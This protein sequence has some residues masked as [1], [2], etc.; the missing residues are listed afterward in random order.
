M[1]HS[2][3]QIF[4]DADRFQD[5]FRAGNYEMLGPS[6]DPFHA[7][8]TRID[9]TRLGMQRSERSGPSAVRSMSDPRR[10]PLMFLADAEQDIPRR[11]GMELS[12]QEIAIHRP[13]STNHLHTQGPSRLA[14]M[15]LAIDDLA[16]AGLAL[17]GR[18]LEPPPLTYLARPAPAQLGR[19]RALHGLAC[20][21]AK[22]DPEALRRPQTAKA[23]EQDL[24]Q[25]MVSCLADHPNDAKRDGGSHGRVMARFEDFLA[26]RQLEPVYLAEICAAIGASERTLRTCC[27]ERLGMGPIRY[28]WLR[29][30]NLAH[31]ALVNADPALRTVTEIVTE[32]GFWELGR[33]SVEYRALFG[34]SPSTSL[35]RPADG[36]DE[37]I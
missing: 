25:A 2:R 21:L 12:A 17:T 32:H 36:I 14:M 20:T 1:P 28:L 9:F 33:F 10:V 31:R 27:Q 30:M 4:D 6:N 8:L 37:N 29:R 3:V 7:E 34:E 26:A 18:E 16:A 19:L 13:G 23:I 24:I 22:T 15:S 11:N 5:A 35:R